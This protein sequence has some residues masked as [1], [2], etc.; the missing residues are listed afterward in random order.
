MDNEYI[1]KKKKSKKSLIAIISLV[2]LGLIGGT[3]AYYQTRDTFSNV[4]N[5]GK[6][7]ITT[8]ETFESPPNW[9][10]GDT[11][12]KEVTVINEGNVDAAVKVCFEEKWEDVNGNELPIVGWDDIPISILDFNSDYRSYWKKACDDN[13]YYYYKAL[14][15]NEETETILESVTFNPE[16]DMDSDMDCVTDA[17][18]HKTTCISKD[19][20]YNEG[21]Y[22]L[23]INI[24]TVQYDKIIEAWNPQYA[25][26]AGGSCYNQDYLES[27]INMLTTSEPTGEGGSSFT[28][29]P[30]ELYN[31]GGIYRYLVEK[32]VFVDSI[33]IPDDAI[34]SW[35]ASVLH[36]G[37]VMSWYT[38]VDND[39]LLERY[40]GA[41]G[42][43]VANPNSLCLFSDYEEVTEL[44]LSGLDISKIENMSYMFYRFGHN[45]DN[46]D[47]SFIA[48]WDM[49][50]VTDMSYM[51][52][53]SGAG[54]STWTVGNLS[55][56]DTSKVTNMS[57]M[58]DGAALNANSFDIS[59]IEN[60]D[61]SNVTDLSYFL[62]QAGHNATTWNIGNLSN[63]DTS[64]VTSMLSMFYNVGINAQMNDIGTLKVYANNIWNM[65]NGAINF[66]GTINIYTNP[67]TYSNAF[68]N[69]AT[70]QGS[71]ITV[72]YTNAVTNIDS[73]IATKSSNS[74]VVKGSIIN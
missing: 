3:V 40:I 22:T 29:E 57:H 13:C 47:L 56:W 1:V 18:T 12:P 26:F 54:S 50:K 23:K 19:G 61:I 8:E 63:W 69:A 51:F 72:N 53:H 49:S 48:D 2:F 64:K 68:Y 42:K 24:E 27:H 67:A 30:L 65:F 17:T 10:P 31:G 71:G 11:V 20:G 73:I 16:T 74:N 28:D 5:S 14:K 35:D 52:A 46:L 32:L 7:V 39:G 37:S 9:T 44:D 59:F 43:V 15:P 36:D 4:F 38:D 62:F 66:K 25:N 21:K 70:N 58:F 45:L 34:T 41:N 60:W 33:D 6:Y 55:N